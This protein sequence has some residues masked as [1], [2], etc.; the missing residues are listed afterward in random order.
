MIS[1]NYFHDYHDIIA[2]VFGLFSP[3]VSMALSEAIRPKK[4]LRSYIDQC[5]SSIDRSN[6]GEHNH[7]LAIKEF[8]KSI[9]FQAYTCKP[10]NYQ[11][12]RYYILYVV[13]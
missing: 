11:F 6:I 8:G 9:I 7:Q 1:Q 2:N 5:S 12:N 10:N 4:A 3:T 13:I